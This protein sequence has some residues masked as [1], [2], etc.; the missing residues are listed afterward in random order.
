MQN[1]E[2]IDKLKKL[3][4][5]LA[6]KYDLEAKIKELP[7]SLDGRVESIERFKK[8]FIEKNAEYE[9]QKEKIGKLKVELQEAEAS[10]ESGEKGMD[11]I[12]TH[13]EYEAL[14]KQ[15]NEANE[16]EQNIRKELQK[17]EKTLAELSETIKDNE[18]LI[19]STEADINEAK[20]NLKKEIDGYKKELEKL[21]K[22]EDAITP[23]IDAEIIFKF[24]RIIQRNS[25]GIVAVKGIVCDG[26]HMILPA[27]FANE[28]HNDEKILFCPYC[29]RI[30]YYEEGD[31][32][33]SNYFQN[34]D[35]GS[36][37]DLD[38][39]EDADESE[40]T[41]DE[42]DDEG[43]ESERSLDYED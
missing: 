42:L 13:R 6:Q 43:E 9:A 24:E 30:L 3:Q 39:D 17:E 21:K 22:K 36:L 19:S 11:S 1:K 7:K 23:G 31:E 28:V 16:R 14:D 33:T 12:T 32:N 35:A 41:G 2:V 27:Q 10:R 20:D 40:Y 8:E 37:A 18:S 15:I 5:I 38:E 26:C 34:E 25:K 4:D 29:S